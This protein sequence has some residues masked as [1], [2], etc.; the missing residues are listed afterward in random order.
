MRGAACVRVAAIVLALL[1]TASGTAHA[2]STA[3][4]TVRDKMAPPKPQRADSVQARMGRGDVMPSIE[5]GDSYTFDR[6]SLFRTG[7]LTV[8]DLLDRIPT[9]TAFRSGWLAAPQTVAYGGDFSRVRL[10]IDGIEL[11]DQQARNGAAPDV[12]SF[13]IW[14]LERLTLVRTAS[15][16]RIEM[17]SWEYRL[18]TPYTRVDVLTGDLST[19]LYRVFYGKRYYNG[20]GLQIAGQQYGVTDTRYGGGGDQFTFLGRY[21]VARELWSL[22][23]TAIRTNSTRTVT[24]RFFG[25]QF[26]PAYRAANTLGYLRGAIGREGSGPFVQVIASTQ[27]LKEY[28]SHLDSAAASRFGFPRDT[29]DTLASTTQYV[30]TAGFDQYGG[31]LRLIERYRRR[32]GRG[33]SSPSATFDVTRGLLAVNALAERDEYGGLTRLEIGGKLT[34]LPFVSV[35]G[36]V[37]Q[38]TPFGD[39]APEHIRQPSSRSARVEGGIRLL[40]GGPW[41]TVGFVTR[42]TAVLVPPTVFDSAF[43]S[44]PV[45][46]QS[47]ATL[48]LRGGLPYGFSIDATGTKWQHPGPYTPEY[49][50]HADLRYFTQWLSR[51]PAGNFSFLVQPTLDYRSSVIFPTIDADRSTIPAK[52]Y[53]VLVELRILRAVISYQ[54]RNITALQ[55]DQVAGYLMPRPL[56]VYGVRW[57]FLN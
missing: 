38:R 28:S 3:S 39:P 27:L 14:A 17:R 23:A 6:E 22:D 53:S 19:N 54:Q 4:D 20:T 35:A 1:G 41:A 43:I 25:G 55:Y 10:F 26:L 2:Q 11:D 34:P 8:G 32:L 9:I 15:E 18:T 51:F 29:A 16:L 13:P 30:A 44:V 36:Y 46:R 56:S 42:D 50:A 37:G 48:G 52:A 24:Q 40:N 21:G 7:A 33:Y 47:G 12:H 45:T 31:R 5:I 49:Q 57:Y